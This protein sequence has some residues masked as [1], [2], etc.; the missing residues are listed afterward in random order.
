[1]HI[2]DFRLTRIRPP[3]APRIV[4]KK[5]RKKKRNAQKHPRELAKTAPA[6]SKPL[7]SQTGDVGG[8]LKARH[9]PPCGV[10]NH[11]T[12]PAEG[13]RYRHRRVGISRLIGQIEPHGPACIYT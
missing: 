1:M 11:G 5:E 8:K 4:T 7:R 6:A 3:T 13:P 2:L 10:T 12:Q 9:E